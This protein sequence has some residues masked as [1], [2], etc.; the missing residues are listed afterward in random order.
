V[1]ETQTYAN[2]VHRPIGWTITAIFAVLALAG[3][4]L[5][6]LRTPSILTVAL[7]MMA[8]AVAGLVVLVR[9]YTTRLQDR[10]IRLEMRLRLSGLGREYDVTRLSVRQLVA[11]RF[12]SDAELGALV[13][14]AVAENLTS[15]QIKRA[16]TNWQ[17][18]RMRT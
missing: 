8:S 16:I 4:V 1:A 12:A 5:F 13:D 18:D 14:R 15:D 9:R 6:V 7:L 3:M 10:I 11:L 17:A 2:H